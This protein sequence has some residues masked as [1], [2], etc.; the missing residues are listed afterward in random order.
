MDFDKNF[1]LIPS[2]IFYIIENDRMIDKCLEEGV[3][4]RR[5]LFFKILNNINLYPLANKK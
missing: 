2:R 5:S 1:F 3:T 4:V